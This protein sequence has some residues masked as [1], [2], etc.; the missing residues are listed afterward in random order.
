MP[1]ANNKY[2]H[3]LLR[4]LNSWWVA[5]SSRSQ[6]FVQR[7]SHSVVVRTTWRGRIGLY[8]E[9]K[10]SFMKKESIV[11]TS[12]AHFRLWV[13]CSQ[14]KKKKRK[15]TSLLSSSAGRISRQN[16]HSS[17]QL[18]LSHR[19]VISWSISSPNNT[20][21]P[22]ILSTCTSENAIPPCFSAVSVHLD[23]MYVLPMVRIFGSCIISYSPLVVTK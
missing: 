2:E 22:T 20:R 4:L 19:P 1:L 23:K 5:W 14:K 16:R 13:L 10:S 6:Y 3:T 7:C 12:P 18:K 21:V 11:E 8:A 9:V 17:T 15:S